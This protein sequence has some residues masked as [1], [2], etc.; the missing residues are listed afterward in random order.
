MK[1]I[2]SWMKASRKSCAL[3]FMSLGMCSAAFSVEK[4]GPV[5]DFAL[6]MDYCYYMVAPPG[7]VQDE[8]EN[9][10]ST[11]LT[12]TLSFLQEHKQDMTMLEAI[13]VVRSECEARIFEAA[14]ARTP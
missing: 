10:Y 6:N 12:N 7:G 13:L 3:L 1:K 8:F 2:S 5:K 14:K 4:N 9:R 11:A